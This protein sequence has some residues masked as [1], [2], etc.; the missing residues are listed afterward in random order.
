FEIGK[1]GWLGL[2]LTCDHQPESDLSQ[3]E[4]MRV[5]AQPGVKF[6][7]TFGARP[8]ADPPAVSFVLR[9]AKRSWVE[10][11]SE[12][13]AVP[14]PVRHRAERHRS[15]VLSRECLQSCDIG[16]KRELAIPDCERRKRIE[17]VKQRAVTTNQRLPV[18]SCRLV[19][20]RYVL[21]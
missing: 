8:I 16:G 5:L 20:R 1:I 7:L 3:M 4:S 19:L 15:V 14:A 18:D 2:S 17:P 9:Q 11:R 21:A 10:S 12:R 6:A 13:R